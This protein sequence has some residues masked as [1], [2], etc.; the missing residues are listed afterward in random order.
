V[1][2]ISPCLGA[3]N[4]ISCAHHQSNLE[5][6]C[7]TCHLATTKQQRIDGHFQKSST[8]DGVNL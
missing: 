6:L 3:H 7:H 4:D 5:V 8:P 2:H 1:N